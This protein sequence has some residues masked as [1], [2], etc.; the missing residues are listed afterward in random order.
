[1]LSEPLAGSPGLRLMLD[2]ADRAEW[3]KWLPVGC[4]YGI[5]TNPLL[6]Q[7]AGVPCALPALAE[8]IGEALKL[9]AREAHAQTW[10]RTR[11][12]YYDRGRELAAIDPRVVVKVPTTVEGAAA[13]AM[14][15]Q[16]G[17]RLTMTAVYSAA[18]ALAADALGA[19]YA[20][21][22]LGRMNDLGRDGFT[23][24]AGMAR[25]VRAHGGTMRILV[26]SLRDP[27]DVVRL[28]G[29]GVDA[30]TFNPKVAAGFFDD[31]KAV[32]AV[33]AFE[34]AAEAA[35]AV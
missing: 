28:A 15:R 18:Q 22:Y 11:A 34:A 8:L 6:L 31:E 13:A 12:L 2:T 1:M 21:P 16:E 24:I 19:D 5:T 20:A 29:E 27:S 9:G 3:A 25:A 14:L 23:E 32:E 4:F 7:A 33:E 35:T 10:G 26:A 17:V 30:F